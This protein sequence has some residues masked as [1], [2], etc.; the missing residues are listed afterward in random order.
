MRGV[1]REELIDFIGSQQAITDETGT[2]E[3]V[4]F[5]LAEQETEPP[6]PEPLSTEPDVFWGRVGA[7]DDV[8]GTVRVPVVSA[9]LPKRLGNFPFWRSQEGFLLVME[10][11]YRNAS[12]VGLDVFLGKRQMSK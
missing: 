4:P 10:E 12:K 7:E 11:I 8:G 5:S 1:D 2:N 6:T 3:A 9:A